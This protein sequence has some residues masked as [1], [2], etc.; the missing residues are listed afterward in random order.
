MWKERSAVRRIVLAIVIA[1]SILAGQNAVGYKPLAPNL[2]HVRTTNSADAHDRLCV[3]VYVNPVGTPGG[4]D[5]I[6]ISQGGEQKSIP[7][8]DHWLEPGQSSD[9]TDVGIHMP[10]KRPIPTAG[11]PDMIISVIG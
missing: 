11:S 4:A 1:A 3:R 5:T 9:W 10:A 6:Y 7:T 8:V 2:W